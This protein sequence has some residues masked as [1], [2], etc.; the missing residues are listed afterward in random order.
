MSVLDHRPAAR[1]TGE[2]HG[3]SREK[4]VV[5]AQL[6]AVLA[7]GIHLAVVP[8][9]L[10]ESVLIAVFFAVVALA[11]FA[12]V[13]ALRWRLPVSVLVTTIG[14]HGALIALYVASRTVDLPFMPAHH[15]GDLVK[16]LPVATGVG[17]G[18][19]AYP[20]SRIEPVGVLDVTCLVAELV[21][22]A[23]LA[24][25]LPARAR[26]H[27]TSAMVVLGLIAV[28]GRSIGLLG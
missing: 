21:L 12:L 28:V 9:H 16:H 14:A 18:I 10:S 27:V 2:P 15:G 11:Q 25:L 19:P 23:A 20:G 7:A 4:Y 17:N 22:M 26:A 3:A 13:V 5:T 1:A 8:E 6:S 24:G